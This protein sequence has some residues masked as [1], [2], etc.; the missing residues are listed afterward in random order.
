VL[1]PCS[2]SRPVSFVSAV[3]EAGQGEPHR[4]VQHRAQAAHR[5]VEAVKVI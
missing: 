3:K 2:G 1:H 4:M 5:R